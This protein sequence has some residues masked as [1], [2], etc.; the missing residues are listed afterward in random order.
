[1]NLRTY[2]VGGLVVGVLCLGWAADH[3]YNKAMTWRN[4]AHQLETVTKQQAATITNI[5][6]RQKKL[7]ALD[8]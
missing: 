5:N 6:Q 8:G 1:M 2:L 4:T 3:Y 7:A